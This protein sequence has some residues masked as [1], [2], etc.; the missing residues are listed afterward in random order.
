MRY[1]EIKFNGFLEGIVIN[2]HMVDDGF[3]FRKEYVSHLVHEGVTYEVR[4]TCR[5]SHSQ[6]YIEGIF[7]T[8]KEKKEF[9]FYYPK[10]IRF[11]K[12]RTRK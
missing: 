11:F 1:N 12:K 2:N 6:V 3:D 4:Y 7:S 10:N 5:K 9:G 8:N